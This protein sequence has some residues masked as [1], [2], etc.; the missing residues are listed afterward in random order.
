[1]L[2]IVR[3]SRERL[4][5]ERYE[6]QLAERE[7][8]VQVLVEQIEYLRAQ[9]HMPTATV[10]HAATPVQLPAFDFSDLPAGVPVEA[11]TVPTDEEEEL[12]ALRQAGIITEAEYAEARER[13]K[14]RSPNDIIE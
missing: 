5:T 4:L 2:R 6:A 7:R 1:M 8:L 3:K 12:L 13:S 11:S 9:L 10:R 14:S